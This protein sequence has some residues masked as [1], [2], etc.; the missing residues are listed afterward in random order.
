LEANVW[1]LYDMH[2]LLWELVWDGYVAAYET[3]PGTDPVVE[4]GTATSY[5][6]R[7]G[8]Y[9]SNAA[10]CRSGNRE[11]VDSGAHAGGFRILRTV[12]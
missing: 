3:L 1:G 10:E 7:G 6:I 11:V 5:V 4:P 8:S 9:G 2:G 12:F